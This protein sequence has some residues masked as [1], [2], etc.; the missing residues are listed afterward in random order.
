MNGCQ[1]TRDGHAGTMT[2]WIV[3]IRLR[4]QVLASMTTVALGEDDK[5]S[6]GEEMKLRGR[7]ASHGTLPRPSPP[8]LPPISSL[9]GEHLLHQHL[10]A[11]QSHVSRAFDD[12]ALMCCQWD[13]A[14]GGGGEGKGK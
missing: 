7:G 13:V 12:L 2:S 14:D 3:E 9:R 5:E 1:E 10:K 8:P 4:R 6:E 11:R